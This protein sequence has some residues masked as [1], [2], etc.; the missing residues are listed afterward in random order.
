M[1]CVKLNVEVANN[2]DIMKT[3]AWCRKKGFKDIGCNTLNSGI[4]WWEDGEYCAQEADDGDSV[5][6]IGTTIFTTTFKEFKKKV[7]AIRKENKLK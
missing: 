6:S 4:T 3:L 2:E 1:W 5:F 7:K